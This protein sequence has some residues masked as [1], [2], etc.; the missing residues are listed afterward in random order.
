MFGV[1]AFPIG[2]ELEET[3]KLTIAKLEKAAE[4]PQQKPDPAMAKVE[5]QKAI[6]AAKLQ[7]NQQQEQARVQAD[8][9]IEQLRLQHE[10]KLEAMRLEY[11][12]QSGEAQQRWQQWQV[13]QQNKVEL[14]AKMQE[15]HQQATL[16][17]MKTEMQV[18]TQIIL[19]H[20]KAAS[21]IEV[22]RI[23]AAASDGAE[24]EN[25]EAS[26]EE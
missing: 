25:R 26:G 16:D 7:A 9:Q 23:G 3:F 5:A 18:Q 4:N 15:A 12:R 10:Q 20:I 8:A 11:Q 13:E 2:K 22:A 19:A 1:R 24:A 14:A 17:R 6:E 21:A